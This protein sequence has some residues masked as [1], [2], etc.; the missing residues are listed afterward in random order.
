MSKIRK[1]R[2]VLKYFQ[3]SLKF[4]GKKGQHYNCIAL[5]IPFGLHSKRR[6]LS[7]EVLGRLVLNELP[8][9]LLASGKPSYVKKLLEQQVNV[10]YWNSPSML[11]LTCLD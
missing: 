9:G 6:S 4:E 3:R 10:N 8:R 7:Y 11:K 2:L 5:K 1:I